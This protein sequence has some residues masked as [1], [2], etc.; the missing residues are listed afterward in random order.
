MTELKIE[1]LHTLL[2]NNY[3]EPFKKR[4]EEIEVIYKP[5]LGAYR[6][7]FESFADHTMRVISE[8]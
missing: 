1:L 4:L 6:G 5:G 3:G 8:S 7:M 2:L